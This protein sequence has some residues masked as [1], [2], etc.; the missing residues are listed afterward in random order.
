MAR[1]GRVKVGRQT[2]Y[3][4]FENVAA[5]REFA[6]QFEA[7]HA[8]HDHD[9]AVPR[10]EEINTADVQSYHTAGAPAWGDKYLTIDGFKA[11]EILTYHHWDG[12]ERL[13]ANPR[14]RPPSCCISPLIVLEKQNI[15]GDGPFVDSGILL[16]HELSS[17][18]G[19]MPDEDFAS[20]LESVKTEGFFDNHIRIYE[21]RVLDGWHR[22]RAALRLNIVR[23]LRFTAWDPDEEGDPVAFV[24]ARNIERRHLNPGQRS[25]IVLSVNKRFG[26]GGDRSKVSNDTLK[27][28][29]ELA[30]EAKVSVA[31]IKRASQV[32][33][34]GRADEVISGEKSAGEVLKEE[35]E[36]ALTTDRENM[37]SSEKMMWQAL[38]DIKERV[39]AQNFITA[40][41]QAHPQWGVDNFPKD[42]YAT[43]IPDIWHTRYNIIHTEIQNGSQW[44]FDF[45]E[46]PHSEP[47]SSKRS[48]VVEDKPESDTTSPTSADVPDSDQ[49][50]VE[51]VIDTTPEKDK[52]APSLSD[53]IQGVRA[54]IRDLLPKWKQD[55]PGTEDATFFQVLDARFR[56]KHT[57]PRGTSPFFFEE[58]DDLYNRM[59]SNELG[60]VDKVRE[61]LGTRS[62]V[63]SEAP[64]AQFEVTSGDTQLNSLTV[65]WVENDQ[66]N[67]VLFEDNGISW[68]GIPLS[69]LPEPLLAEILEFVRG[70]YTW[71]A[72]HE[73][74]L[75]QK[76]NA[77]FLE[78]KHR[79]KS[80]LK[81]FKYLTGEDVCKAYQLKEK[82]LQ[83]NVIVPTDYLNTYRFM[84]K[85]DPCLL[86]GLRELYPISF[87]NE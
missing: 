2:N 37:K 35:K 73:P 41:C 39:H 32:E 74:E 11:S 66:H 22:Y 46:G 12:V 72:K 68:S 26:H 7:Y 27:T 67:T 85:D 59:K 77:E 86:E 49:E 34:L 56:M 47:G 19:D 82:N 28:H 80:V 81:D 50:P 48:E 54:E 18:F 30:E 40:A 57:I 55:N 58:L 83:T 87:S 52:S 17:I 65:G 70:T 33:N 8:S 14:Y 15:G 4:K 36:K 21:G 16:R 10:F 23:K 3:I 25:Q 69:T 76:F 71:D 38:W 45:I 62:A 75:R 53:K 51:L 9:G 79:H 44:M 6:K 42:A 61:M 60:L 13:H 24:S 78:W 20:L 31:T 43:D 5:R 1:Y 63:E 84:E 29:E 64:D